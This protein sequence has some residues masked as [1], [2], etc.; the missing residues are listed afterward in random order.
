MNSNNS[1]YRLWR[2]IKSIFFHGFLTLLPIVLTTTLFVFF[3]RLINKWVTPLHALVP[4]L[5]QNLPYSELILG[6]TLIFLLGA[7]LKYFLLQPIIHFFESVLSKI[8]LIRSVYFGIKQLIHA[9]SGYDETTFNQVVL[10]EYPRKGIYSIGFITGEP[11][12]HFEL[13]T[14]TKYYHVYIPSV[15]NPTTGH[16]TIVSEQDIKKTALTRQDALAIIIS[17]GIIQ[18]EKF[19]E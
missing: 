4:R 8:P 19:V 7:V 13:G 16:F 15:P 11:H 17:G 6:I 2:S 10:V 9:F 14:D 3:F 5:F 1:F 18:P 12:P